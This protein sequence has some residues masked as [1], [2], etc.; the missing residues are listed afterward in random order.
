MQTQL[1]MFGAAT[2]LLACSARTGLGS[3][4]S[5]AGGSASSGG[6]G[7]FVSTGAQGGEGGAFSCATLRWVGE[8]LR[9]PI[10]VGN[11][12]LHAPKL[13]RIGANDFAVAVESE[14]MGGRLVASFPVRDPF[15]TWPP[16]IAVADANFPSPG[17]F[18]IGESDTGFFGFSAADESGNLILGQAE[19]GQNGSTLVAFPVGA[20]GIHFLS[21]NG[22]G[23]YLVGEGDAGFLRIY[24]FRAFSPDAEPFA[25]GSFGCATPRVIASAV[26]VLGDFLVASAVDAPFEDCLDPDLPGPP[27]IAQVERLDTEGTGTQGDFLMR[28]APIAE[29]MLAPKEGGA[30]MGVRD[31]GSGTFEVYDVSSDGRFGDPTLHYVSKQTVTAHALTAAGPTFAIAEL[32]SANVQPGGDLILSIIVDFST[33]SLR[34][35]PFGSIFP[36]DVPSLAAS[37]DGRSLLLAFSAIDEGIATVIVWRA[38]CADVGD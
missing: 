32:L 14:G 11:D 31:E 5:D 4:G 3:D 1:S 25:L 16:Q 38:D 18:G 13:V 19:P 30:W 29:L 9:V 7:G 26:P 28:N 33:V 2:L 12:T 20:Q 37:D 8:P 10:P 34:L 27:V 36:D 22:L 15:G 24:G 35:E 21:R 6:S 23:Q 17:R